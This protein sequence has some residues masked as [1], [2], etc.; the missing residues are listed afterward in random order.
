MDGQV[1]WDF[2]FLEKMGYPLDIIEEHIFLW[3][4]ERGVEG[5]SSSRGKVR[6]FGQEEEY[7][8]EFWAI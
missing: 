6:G 2:F 4:E 1:Q 3:W 7:I 5:M 8:K